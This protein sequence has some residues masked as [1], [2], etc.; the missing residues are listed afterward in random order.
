MSEVT[1][2]VTEEVVE[3]YDVGM[4]GPKGD[5]VA[6]STVESDCIAG[7]NLSALRAVRIVSE[8]AFYS[9]AANLAHKNMAVGITKT[10][11]DALE[12]VTIVTS[13]V[14]TDDSW[15]WDTSKQIYLGVDGALTQANVG[16]FSQVVGVP[17]GTKGIKLNICSSIERI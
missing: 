13:G 15:N 7:E 16:L 9:S 3:I 1:V 12:S 8:Q 2:V 17:Y 10:S 4:Q 6:A 5:S 11:A 14:I